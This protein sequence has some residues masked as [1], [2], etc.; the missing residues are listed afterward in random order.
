MDTPRLLAIVCF[1]LGV[2]I[3]LGAVSGAFFAAA[4]PPMDV[5]ATSTLLVFLLFGAYAF[6]LGQPSKAT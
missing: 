4:T 1:V 6:L 3:Y 2:V 5:G